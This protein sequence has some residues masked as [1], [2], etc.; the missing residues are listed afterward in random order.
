MIMDQ[1]SLNHLRQEDRKQLETLLAAI[2]GAMNAL[3]RDACGDW[4]ITGSRASGSAKAWTYAKRALASLCPVITQ[5][6]DREGILILDQMPDADQA[7]TLRDYIGLRQTRDMPSGQ[8]QKAREA[9]TKGSIGSPMRY[10]EPEAPD[11]LPAPQASDSGPAEGGPH[12]GA[13]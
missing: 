6:G 8:I 2:N 12:A 9:V 7:A 5:D 3:R 1:A 11:G 4:T 13:N 10:S